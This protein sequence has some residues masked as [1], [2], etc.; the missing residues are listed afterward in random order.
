MNALVFGGN[1]FIGSH[2]V[3]QLGQLDWDVKNPLSSEVDLLNPGSIVEILRSYQPDVIINC[4]GVVENNDKAL[5]NIEFTK[6]I[7]NAVIESKTSPKRVIISGSAA[8]YGYVSESDLPISE[9]QPL[10]A[11][12]A[13]GRA[14]IEEDLLAQKFAKE[15]NLP[16][17]VMRIFNPIGVGLGPRFLTSNIIRQIKEIRNK[18][19]DSVEI[20]RLDS[21]RDYIDIEDLS[22]AIVSLAKIPELSSAIYNIGSGVSV[23]NGQIA[24]LMLEESGLENIKVIEES[25]TPERLVACRAD[26]GLI[27]KDAGWVPRVGIEDTIRQIIQ[28]EG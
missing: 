10:S 22:N 13:Y 5:L 20:M 27:K 11:E 18:N 6:N 26:I 21:L 17:I 12:S 7:L 23:S 2:V 3:R 9:S 15:H 19:K 16:V 4:A 24:Q 8:E 28:K 14:K 25:E 1:G